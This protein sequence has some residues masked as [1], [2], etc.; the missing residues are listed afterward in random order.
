MFFT[1]RIPEKGTM[2]GDEE[3]DAY[4]DEAWKATFSGIDESFIN[5]V[6]SIK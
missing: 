3:V 4:N 5:R 6:L 2:A 1:K